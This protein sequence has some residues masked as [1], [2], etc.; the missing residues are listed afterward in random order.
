MWQWCKLYKRFYFLDS[1]IL[2]FHVN[3]WIHF[4]LSVILRFYNEHKIKRVKYKEEPSILDSPIQSFRDSRM[5]FQCSFISTY[6]SELGE[7]NLTD[8]SVT[9]P[10]LSATGN[11]RGSKFS[12]WNNQKKNRAHK[13]PSASLLSAYRIVNEGKPRKAST[14]EFML[15]QQSLA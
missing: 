15:T 3:C 5:H 2:K 9:L 12:C 11:T 8:C 6:I 1:W 13:M 4:S 14:T 10:F 7:R